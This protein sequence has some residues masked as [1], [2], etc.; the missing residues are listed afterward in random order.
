VRNIWT[1]RYTAWAEC[2][3]FTSQ[4]NYFVSL[5]NPNR[6]MLF[7]E[8]ITAYC[9]N[10]TEHTDT[11]CGQNAEFVPHRKQITSALQ[12]PTGLSWLGKNS[13]FIVRTI[14]TQRYTEYA[15]CRVYTSKETY[16][17]SATNPNRLML[18]GETVAY[19]PENHTEHTDTRC[20]QKLEVVPHRNN[21]RS[22]LPT[23]TG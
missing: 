20:W 23:P 22:P 1:H 7:G 14:W 12:S 13:L 2:R 17:V 8:R 3:D 16:F 4:E 19:Y 10:H 15:E 18:C 6:L 5:T 9:E 11:L 21:I